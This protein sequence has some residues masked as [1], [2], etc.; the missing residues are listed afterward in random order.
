MKTAR[1]S[2]DCQCAM[3][4]TLSFSLASHTQSRCE[5]GVL[6]AGGLLVK[7]FSTTD[8]SSDPT[9]INKDLGLFVRR[10]SNCS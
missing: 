9:P 3:M 2:A 1:D 8:S 4:F 5:K 10:Y 6:C 7:G